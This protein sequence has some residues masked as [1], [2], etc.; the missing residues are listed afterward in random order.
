M[1]K[2]V[3]NELEQVV[4]RVVDEM[5]RTLE[6]IPESEPFGAEKLSPVEQIQRYL[7]MRDDFQAWAE[8]IE[9]QGMKATLKYATTMEGRIRKEIGNHAERTG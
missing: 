2:P 3:Q 9:E 1:A 8:L 5:N 7:E 4:D 6:G